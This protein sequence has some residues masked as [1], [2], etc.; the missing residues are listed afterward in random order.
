MPENNDKERLRIIAKYTSAAFEMAAVIVLGALGGRWLDGEFSTSPVWTLV[1]TV[2]S[3][4]LGLYLF[5][6]DIIKK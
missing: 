2:V 1:L 6:K 3:V 4:A 5:I